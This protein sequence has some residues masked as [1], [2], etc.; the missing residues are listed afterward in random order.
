MTSKAW[1]FKERPTSTLAPAP[2]SIS[3]SPVLLV[4]ENKKS[5]IVP[6]EVQGDRRNVE[7]RFNMNAL[8]DSGA[9]GTFINK[10][11]VLEQKIALAPLDKN[12]MPLNV[13]GTK[14]KSGVI[15]HCTWLNLKIGKWNVPTRFLVTDLRKEEIILELPWLKEH[16]PQ[17]N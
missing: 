1:V 4:N 6:F 17:I 11:F 2:D 16:N 10:K 12:I 15:R 13:D 5:F 7:I 9:D 3:I 8:I 14:N